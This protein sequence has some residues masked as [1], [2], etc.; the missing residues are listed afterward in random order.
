MTTT[1]GSKT[2]QL[3]LSQH[4][5]Q[6]DIGR[7]RT[8]DFDPKSTKDFYYRFDG[9]NGKYFGEF[10]APVSYEVG[11]GAWNSHYRPPQYGGKSEVKNFYDKSHLNVKSY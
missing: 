4:V 11:D 6:Y 2:R 1:V 3:T 9:E 7:T 10:P 8:T 5:H